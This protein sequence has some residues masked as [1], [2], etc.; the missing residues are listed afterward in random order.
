MGKWG[1]A[2]CSNAFCDAKLA[3]LNVVGDTATVFPILARGD[4]I[5]V[6]GTHT[7]QFVGNELRVITSNSNRLTYRMRDT[8][9]LEVYGLSANGSVVVWGVLARE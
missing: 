7:A 1:G 9:T 3:V 6:T 8:N 5:R 2:I 4:R